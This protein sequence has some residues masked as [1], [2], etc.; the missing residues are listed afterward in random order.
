MKVRDSGS[1]RRT[2]LG[3]DEEEAIAGTDIQRRAE[4]GGSSVSCAEAPGECALRG[5][6]VGGFGGR[7][8]SGGFGKLR[9]TGRVR[10]RSAHV[11]P[12]G[13]TTWFRAIRAH[14]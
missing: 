6:R 4:E 3:V 14:R 9:E 2:K 7:E 5:N 10:E 11:L 1:E 13:M 12:A 8:V